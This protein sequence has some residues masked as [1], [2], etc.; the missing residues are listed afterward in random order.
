MKAGRDTARMELF[1]RK[2]A[3]FAAQGNFTDATKKLAEINASGGA[4]DAIAF[5]AAIKAF[6]ALPGGSKAGDMK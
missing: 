6:R 2:A 3:E 1:F 4:K 5:Q